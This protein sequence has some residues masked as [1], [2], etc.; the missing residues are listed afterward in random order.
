MSRITQ[1]I[2]NIIAGISQQP[3][4]LR[5]MEQLE[6]QINGFSTEA[7]G[8]QK[9][10]PTVHIGPFNMQEQNGVKPKLH[11]I[12][13]DEKEKYFVSFTGKSVYVNDLDAR[14]YTVHN[15]TDPYIECSNPRRELKIVTVA[16]YSFIVN[17][18]KTTAMKT[19]NNYSEYSKGALVVVKNGQYGRNYEIL[20][21]NEVI[22]YVQTPDGSS[23][24]HS[25]SIGTDVIANQLA[26]N[27][28]GKTG[29]RITADVTYTDTY[30]LIKNAQAV[31]GDPEIRTRRLWN[32]KSGYRITFSGKFRGDKKENRT[33][34]TVTQKSNN[35]EI[36]T[37]T[38]TTRPTVTRRNNYLIIHGF[39]GTPLSDNDINRIT[40]AFNLAEAYE[41]T[42]G[43]S[44]LYIHDLKG[45]NIKARDGFNNQ[46]I[47]AFTNEVR[48]ITDLPP[49]APDGYIVKI[50][51]ESNKDDDYYLKYSAVSNN[52]TE[53]IQ[54][55]LTTEID[56]MTMPHALIRNNDG[57]FTISP[58]EWVPRTTGDEDSNPIP[59]FIGQK[60]NDLFFFRNRLGLLAG[61]NVC[62]SASGDYFN[63]FVD[64][65][66]GIVDT[67][68]IDLQV[69]ST[70]ISTLYHAVP[71]NQDLYL[72]SNEVQFILHA[73][74]VLTP[75]NA[76]ITQITAFSNDIAVRPEVSGR[77][78]YFTNK[79]AQYTTVK[80]YYA[81]AS[82]SAIKDSTD[83]TNHVPNYLDN[84]IYE[85]ISS[86]SENLLLA[87]S[88]GASN[89]I[90]VYKY[91]YVNESK[92]Q[93]SW[94]HWEFTGEILGADFINS[95]LYL[96]IKRNEHI[97]L[98]KLY[99]NYNTKDFK[100]EPYRLL[101][102]RKQRVTV[103]GEYD[104]YANS[105]TWNAEPIF[106]NKPGEDCLYYLVL[107]DGRLFVSTSQTFTIKTTEDL[108][109]LT[110]TVG[111]SYDFKITLSPIYVKQSDQSGTRPMSN[112]RLI[113]QN[114]RM[115][116]AG[117]GELVARVE[118][119]GKPP[120]TY[121]LT[122][123]TLGYPTNHANT[124]P[125]ATGEWKIPIHGTNTE[126]TISISNI[127]P[128]PSALIGFSWEGNVTQRFQ[129]I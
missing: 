79:R 24:E 110:G 103:H 32:T 52:W 78:I 65:A 7:D 29:N 77:N 2:K 16:D 123:R 50:T 112:Y 28:T 47:V 41:V 58:L 68:P 61:E 55:G 89:K 107:D 126:T 36:L 92:V 88:T 121:K 3:P 73:D 69:S 23:P 101:L 11:L 108:N 54:P 31:Q 51:G 67:D 111:I 100:E 33:Q 119:T 84:D 120:H 95:T 56:E 25:K 45:K 83:I 102:D 62:L 86:G 5:H 57:T 113:L 30:I 42:K 43:D 117:T 82:D 74:G 114:I 76:Y 64:S 19:T 10:P 96:V 105:F 18:T 22:G 106:N 104:I 27:L 115:H 72:F 44:W 124:H 87:L 122:A 91:L 63:F 39:K 85:I 90:F 93:A 98:E 71:F 70:K 48:K 128:L 125:I 35:I 75:K 20:L 81:L 40:P 13:R 109:N 1:T 46:S 34:Y 116:Y 99:I 118:S 94:S 129:Q 15:A 9:R 127:S 59:S 8:L 53:T 26:D 37:N 97:Y 6:E 14:P 38:G 80:E 49:T 21:D 4:L 60:I 17:T 12:N 66:T